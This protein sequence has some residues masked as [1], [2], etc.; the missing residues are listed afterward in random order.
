MLFAAFLLMAGLAACTP[1]EENNERPDKAP[2]VEFSI[3]DATLNVMVDE[4]V[5]FKA[6]IVEGN[7]VSST[8]TV[9]GELVAR[10][11]SLTWVFTKVGTS[12]V[13]FLAEND[14]GKVE[15]D[16]TVNVAGIPLDVT[17]SVEEDII[18]AVIGTPVEVSVTVTGGDKGTVHAWKLDGEDAGEG[19]SF[20]KTFAEE[21]IG[22]HTL[23]YSGINVDGMTA[24]RVWTIEVRDLPLE[25]SFTP[26]ADELTA[27]VGDQVAFAAQIIHGAGGAAY[28]WKVDGTQISTSA[29]YSYDCTVKSNHTVTCA[30]TNAAGEKVEK[31]WALSVKN[32]PLQ[33]VFT[34][35]NPV[36]AATIGDNLDFSATVTAGGEGVNY[37]WKVNDVQVATTASYTYGCPEEGNFTVSCTVTNV[38]DDQAQ[39]SWLVTVSSQPVTPADL[40][41]D[42]EYDAIGSWF[43]L[44]ENQPGIELVENPLKSGLNTSDKCLRDKV[45]G[46]GGTSGY[47]TMKGPVML[48]QK[49]FDISKYNGIRFLIYLNGNQYYPRVEHAGTKYPSVAPPQFNGEWEILEFRLPDGAKF[50][51]TKNIVFRPLLQESGS[52][53]TGGNTEDAT[54]NRTIFIDNI[55]FLE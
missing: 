28:V 6:T 41:D 53:I 29:S 16:Y 4:S 44:G 1:T 50:D 32:L 3:T 43:N 15:Q 26:A 39:K 51:N 31:S 22:T 37:S 8:W 55:E 46:S 38:D 19:L 21:E 18:R 47:F 54:N 12:K 7:N 24:V 52:N 9:D 17:Y 42:F 25:V 27:T 48:S 40:F 36:I 34:P 2:A 45:Y 5:E 14:L 30:V 20:T 23:A 33:V 35:E 11:P 10:T 13:H 49:N